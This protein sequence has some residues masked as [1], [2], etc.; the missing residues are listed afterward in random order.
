MHDVSTTRN[1]SLTNFLTSFKLL[2]KQ[3]ATMVM[4]TCFLVL[5]SSWVVHTT[6]CFNLESSLNL[7]AHLKPAFLGRQRP[8]SSQLYL[9]QNSE[10]PSPGTTPTSPTKNKSRLYSFT[11]SRRLARGH[12]FSSKQEFLDY[13]CAGAYQLPKNA[14]VVWQTEW[15]GWEDWLGIPWDFQNGREFARNLQLNTEDEYLTI[16][17]ENKITSEDDPASRL[18]VRPDLYYKQEWQSWDDWLADRSLVGR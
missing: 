7:P 9:A 12:G 6:N 8:S 11:E 4:Q 10:D 14:E 15:K 18:P 17:R 13:D 5:C 16:F 2:H 3:L 1:E